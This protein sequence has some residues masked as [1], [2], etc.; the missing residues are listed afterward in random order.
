MIA[1]LYIFSY[2]SV[3][4]S[5]LIVLGTFQEIAKNGLFLGLWKVPRCGKQV[6]HIAW[7]KLRFTHTSHNPY[8]GCCIFSSQIYSA[9]C[10]HNP[11]SPALTAGA[12]L[13][14]CLRI[15]LLSL[16]SGIACMIQSARLT[17]FFFRK[18]FSNELRNLR[19]G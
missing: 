8:L 12:P 15:Q 2:V 13:V 16:V 1:Q 17:K 6:S 9:A 3:S 11:V 18:G 7:I 10:A 19:S 4:K 5:L 14:L